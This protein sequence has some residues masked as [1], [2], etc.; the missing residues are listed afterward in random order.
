MWLAQLWRADARWPQSRGHFLKSRRIVARFNARAAVI[1]TLRTKFSPIG[2]HCSSNQLRFLK[3]WRCRYLVVG[4]RPLS[5]VQRAD[6]FRSS[7][8][9]RQRQPEHTPTRSQA[10]RAGYRSRAG[11]D[12]RRHLLRTEHYEHHHDSACASSTEVGL[13]QCGRSARHPTRYAQNPDLAEP[14]RVRT[15]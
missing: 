11:R 12:T 2:H 5:I 8:R 15:R 10:D 13:S 14:I 6:Q 9:P 7:P 1:D 3:L 4:T